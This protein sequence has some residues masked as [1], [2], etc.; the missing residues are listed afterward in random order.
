MSLLV[1]AWELREKNRLSFLSVLGTAE[2]AGCKAKR[3]F[4]PLCVFTRAHS[5]LQCLPG[6]E[7]RMGTENP[8]PALW[9]AV[10][11]L[12]PCKGSV[13]QQRGIWRMHLPGFAEEES[14]GGGGV[15]LLAWRD[16]P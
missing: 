14:P 2:F 10:V 9:G 7:D 12:C 4:S 13:V 6:G 16:P 8:G 11:G 3:T 1:P 5:V 15:A